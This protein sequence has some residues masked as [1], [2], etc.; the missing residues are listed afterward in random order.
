[1]TEPATSRAIVEG[2][3]VFSSEVGTGSRE[4][5]TT[6]QGDLQLFRFNLNRN[7]SSGCGRSEARD[8]GHAAFKLALPLVVE[9]CG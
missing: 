5:S 1:M 8:A 6:E 4:E 2:S 7:D 9:T 3:R